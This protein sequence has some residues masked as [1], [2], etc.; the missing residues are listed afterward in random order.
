MIRGA[1]VDVCR[2]RHS[3]EHGQIVLSCSVMCRDPECALR[4]R[5]AAHVRSADQIFE[6]MLRI[7]R[8][9]L[10]NGALVQEATC[11]SRNVVAQPKGGAACPAS[12]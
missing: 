11:L 12:A 10:S 3:D 6:P 2:S 1:N 8:Q 4:D 5:C 9:R 7:R